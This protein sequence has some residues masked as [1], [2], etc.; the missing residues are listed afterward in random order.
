[1]TTRCPRAHRRTSR[2]CRP[3]PSHGRRP[4][5]PTRTCPT[6]SCWLS[7]RGFVSGE[8]V[9]GRWKRGRFFEAVYKGRAWLVCFNLPFDVSRLAVAATPARGRMLGGFSLILGEHWDPATRAWVENRY[10][11]RV[12]IKA[13]DPKRALK[14]LSTP[15]DPDDADTVETASVT[16]SKKRGFRGHLL[17][18]RTLA[19]ALTDRGH[20][21]ESACQAFGVPYT[22]RVVEHGAALSWE[23][24]D[25]CRE[26]VAATSALAGAM[27]D[28]YLKHPIDL[29][30][31]KA[32]SPASIGKDHIDGF[33]V[34]APLVR[35]P[36]FP[37]HL[38][39]WAMTAYYGGRTE[40]RIRRTPVPVRHLDFTSMYPTCCALMGIWSLTTARRIAT[41]DA[42]A[43]VRRLLAQ[44]TISRCLDRALWKEL[45]CLVQIIPAGDYIGP[46]R[47]AFTP[48]GYDEQRRTSEGIPPPSLSIGINPLNTQG[49]PIWVT[50]ADLIASK[51]FTGKIPRILRAVS[52]HPAGGPQRLRALKLG[53]LVDF[54]PRE[55]LYVHLVEERH[56]VLR[57]DDADTPERRA[58]AQFLKT[59][60]NA[61]SYG[62]Y[63]EA[64]Q[65][66]LAKGE[67]ERVRIHG[68]DDA[69][70]EQLVPRPEDPGR[71]AFPPIAAAITSGG[72]LILA[73]L[74]TLV[75]E[76]GGEYAYIDT[77]S[78]FVVASRKGGLV[79]CPGGPHLLRDERPA[80]RAL[81]WEQ[82]A[83]IQRAFHALNP[84]DPALVPELLKL[85]ET[86]YRPSTKAPVR[87]RELYQYAISAKRYALYTLN[88]K[89]EP[90]IVK[91]SEHGLGHLLNPTDPDSQDRAWI[92]T[93]WTIVI[94]RAL[95]LPYALPTWFQHP[96]ITRVGVA[97]PAMLA[98]F[99]NLNAGK[100]YA[101]RIKPFN[102]LLSCQVARLSHPAGV[103]PEQFHLI[104]PY[105]PN[106]RGWILGPWHDLHGTGSWYITT[107][108]ATSTDERIVRVKTIRDVFNEHTTH[109]ELKSLDAAGNPCAEHTAGLLRRRPV[110]IEPHSIRYIGKE[111]N[112]LHDVDAGLVH[113]EDDILASYRDPR[114]ERDE[115]SQVHLPRLRKTGV[116][117]LHRQTGIPVRT[118]RDLLAGRAHPRRK[119]RAKLIEAL[120]G[121]VS[122][123]ADH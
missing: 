1:M 28:E 30:A 58:L 76:A 14:R 32:Y 50:L 7:R 110:T 23:Y 105:T 8:R 61:T 63:A 100:S 82:V 107:T 95:G 6:V 80:I 37:R 59:L 10:C 19:F 13:L 96:A 114:D 62:I 42:T 41:R 98:V 27:L 60:A 4:S 53:G 12:A 25:Y 74:E 122:R 99:R 54:D 9:D 71:F 66:E 103:E 45:V 116:A 93:V 115:W 46:V 48:R 70:F 72:R 39:G 106:P 77:D 15:H 88:V 68:L 111:S 5:T 109:P 49:T 57:S 56:R 2:S 78:M 117:L 47:A 64:N 22:K 18:A 89:G 92:T 34:E 121:Q 97:S 36:E 84:Y 112:R 108:N 81:S 79:A 26:D 16:G 17:D 55:D 85:E 38:L 87:Q 43:R 44:L 91:A 40:T 33:G 20:T 35:E 104:R 11:P 120:G 123:H 67:T 21:L 51:L 83:G 101:D 3:T 113:R 90:V 119:T 75:L 86:N 31:T 69:P 94:R 24:V 52:F 73:V 118:L 29:Q 102:F 65:R